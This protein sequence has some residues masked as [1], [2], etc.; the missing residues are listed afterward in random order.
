L[1]QHWKV[2]GINIEIK[3]FCH[4]QDIVSR[5]IDRLDCRLHM[6]L[7]DLSQFLKEHYQ[8]LER[9]IRHLLNVTGIKF[10]RRGPITARHLSS[11]SGAT[12]PYLHNNSV[13]EYNGDPSIAGRM[14]GYEDGMSK[15]SVAPSAVAAFAY[16]P[17]V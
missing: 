9:A 3:A 10:T 6:M 15:L 13:G 8:L 4:P 12:A 11:V 17:K 5:N 7:D 2:P 16:S 14:A 1:F